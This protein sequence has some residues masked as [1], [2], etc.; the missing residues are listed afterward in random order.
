MDNAT[1]RI[2]DVRIARSALTKTLVHRKIKL[3]RRTNADPV[4]EEMLFSLPIGPYRARWMIRLNLTH[5]SVTC[6]GGV[7][8]TFF[9]HNL[10]VFA[11]E[12]IQLQTITKLVS[13]ALREL[14]GLILPD[15]F[16]PFIERVELTRHH[17]LPPE[18]DKE[19]AQRRIDL[20][21][22]TL[23]PSRYSNE[24]RNHDNPGTTR[25]GKTKSSRVCRI[26][27]P[28]TKFDERLK[29]K[30]RPA[31]IPLDDWT[32]LC[33]ACDRH[34]RVEIMLNKRELESV[35]LNRLSGWT[36]ASVVL[37]LLE[38]RY[39]RFGLSVKYRADQDGFSPEFV[40]D[41]H[42]TFVGYARYFFSAGARGTAPNTRSGSTPR[43]KKFMLAHGYNVD[44]AFARHKFLAHE[45]HE[46][47]RPDRAS[48]LP[49]DIRRNQILFRRW[50][51]ES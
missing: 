21:L 37:S 11:N 18:F 45:L 32:A 51:E 4:S 2:P 48:N 10:Y 3:T 25:I 42:P 17:T 36:D 47:L 6:S 22:M 31:H 41:K 8:R 35:S 7:T 34:L 14:P 1:F 5:G 26:Y 20:M 46:V 40:G 28:A 27:D 24:G 30:G 19:D 29:E 16:E 38:S 50:W 39:R 44:A 12:A 13:T 33:N 23:F 49:Q 43:Y 15:E 9:G